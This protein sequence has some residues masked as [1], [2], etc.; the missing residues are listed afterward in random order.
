MKSTTL[1]ALALAFC[2]GL[3]SATLPPPTAAAAQAQAAKKAVADAQ[4]AKDKQALLDKM[5]AITASWRG[6][7]GAK[8]WKLNPP[9][10][11]P[12]PSASLT[13]PANQSAPSGQPEGKLT[14]VGAAAPMTSEKSGTAA[15]SADAKT[16]PSPA[17]STV[18]TK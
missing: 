2:S 14:A 17:A 7:A 3:A 6:K 9:T 11:L 13:A 8:G 1:V 15:P 12:A 16:A 10:P 4:A 5:D 18:K